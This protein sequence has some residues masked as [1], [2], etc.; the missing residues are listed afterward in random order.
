ML[1]EGSSEGLGDSKELW[2][3]KYGKAV[4]YGGS[5]VPASTFKN[6]SPMRRFDLPNSPGALPPAEDDES[7]RKR[8]G[9]QYYQDKT[10]ILEERIELLE[11][12]LAEAKRH[13]QNS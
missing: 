11:S 9:M 7:A 3:G 12:K 13:S 4:S 8:E 5:D 10:R 1:L 2:L 6:S